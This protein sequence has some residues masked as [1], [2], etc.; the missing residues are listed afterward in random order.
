MGGGDE[1]RARGL[2]E[3]TEMNTEKN[4]MKIEVE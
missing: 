2:T 1:E 4:E 3:K